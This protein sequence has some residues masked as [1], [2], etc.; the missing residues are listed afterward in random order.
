MSDNEEKRVVVAV[1][2]TVTPEMRLAAFKAVEPALIEAFGPEYRE[3]GI[4]GVITQEQAHSVCASFAL[5]ISLM[6]DIQIGIKNGTGFASTLRSFADACDVGD[7][8]TMNNQT[9]PGTKD[10]LN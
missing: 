10:R 6:A 3:Q 1:H 5:I 7:V 2:R 4:D 9:I 8:P